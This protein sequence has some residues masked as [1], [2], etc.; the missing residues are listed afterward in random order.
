[1]SVSSGKRRLKR[2]ALRSLVLLLGVVLGLIVAEV[3]LWSF[4]L[5]RIYRPREATGQFAF[6]RGLGPQEVAYT[7]APSTTIRF[8]YDGNPRQYFGRVDQVDHVTNAAGFRGTTFPIQVDPSG[9]VTVLEKPE[10]TA[11]RAFLGDSFTFGEGVWFDDTYPELT[12]RLLA[13]HYAESDW[14]F[15]ASNFGVGGYNTAQALAVFQRWVLDIDPDAV[16]LGYVLNDAEPPIFQLTPAG[17]PVRRKLAVE[18]VAGE[19]APPANPLFRLRTARLAWQF[20]D[21]RRQT[22]A[23][24]AHY[25]SLYRSTNPDW[26]R[27]R[28]ALREL[29]TACQER[30]IPLVVLFFPLLYEINDRY[31]LSDI[32]TLI[33]EELDKTDAEF[34]DLLPLLKGH[35]AAD[36]W[37]HPTDHHPNEKVHA[38]AARA[39]TDRLVARKLWE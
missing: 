31:P 36:L 22:R 15:E 4:N 24:L 37:V 16:V 19:F 30:N 5:P 38:I 28:A 32:H 35:K 10:H 2:L 7:N 17:K 26:E 14:S 12:A 39:V 18:D 29:A 9:H 20:I 13:Q 8:V 6:V 34:V 25:R 21:Q 27:N 1:M 33:K 11:R 23:T 3:A